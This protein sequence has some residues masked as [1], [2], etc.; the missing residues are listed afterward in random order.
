MVDEPWRLQ[1]GAAVFED[2]VRFTVWAPNVSSLSVRLGDSPPLAME[3]DEAGYYTL[4]VPGVGEGARYH[5]LLDGNSSRPDPASRFQPEGVHGPSEV[6]DPNGF[7]WTDHDWPGMAL[8]KTIL[9]EL[10]VGT[11]TPEGTFSAI[12][13]RLPYLRH[14]LG[15]TAIELMPVAQFP[16]HRNWG[17]DGTFLF[18][19]QNSYG[20]PRG[21]KE[22]INA[23]HR[24]GLAVVLDVVYNHLGPEGNYLAEYGAYLTDRY[25]TPWGAAMNFD[26]PQSDPVRRFI[27]DNALYWVTEF[28]V[29]G[30]RLDAVHGIFDLSARH[31]L[32]ELRAA[33]HRQARALGR[34]VAV[35]AES[36]LNDARLIHPPRKGGYG[37]D[38]QWNDDFHHS[39]HSLLTGE[40]TGYYEDFGDIGQMGKAL[41]EGFVYGGAYSV[42]R[43]R[44]HGNS[45]KGISP[46]RFVVY[47]QNH[48]QVGNRMMGE[49]LSALVSREALKLAAGIVLLSPNI[50][51]L[52]MGEEY[53]EDAPFQY[54]VNHTDPA[55][56]EAV[57]EGRR[58]EFDFEEAGTVPDPE[59]EATF[60][61]SKINPEKRAAGENRTLFEFYRTLIR[62]RREIPAL[63]S[64]CR[65]GKEVRTLRRRNILFWKRKKDGDCV[66]GIFNFSAAPA[67]ASI[68]VSGGPWFRILDSADPAWGGPGTAAPESLPPDSGEISLPLSG[69]SFVL[70]RRPPAGP[71]TPRA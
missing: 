37:I 1:L 16:G 55:L 23:C 43:K 48:D 35:I 67:E 13:P 52:F 20:G 34:P 3:Q 53:G 25:K 29:D 19:P 66:V 47:S 71:E 41:R 68:S 40:R 2:G 56:R 63:A 15:I 59:D 65:K 44:R 11:F 24:A 6:V 42:F 39:L 28:R 7:P 54:F 58:R 36:D 8:E 26:G 27:I 9:Y 10:H 22:L 70:Y 4:H 32:D 69:Q 46:A 17:Y 18:A 21:L 14:E 50:P 30:L 62:M 49:R 45:S 51:L 12:I 61:R 5:Y 38:A 31:I 64:L 33:V 60:Q 57:R